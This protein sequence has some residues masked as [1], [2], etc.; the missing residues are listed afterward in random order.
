[1]IKKFLKYM[2]G[3][4]L[5]LIIGFLSTII[6]TR[7]VSPTEMGKY[8]LFTTI[9]NIIS[10]FI[11]L[12]FDQSYVRFFNEEKKANISNLLRKS[13]LVPLSFG[14]IIC[15]LVLI[16]YKWISTYIVGEIS[17]WFII[18]FCIYILTYIIFRIGL[19]HIRMKQKATMYSVLSVLQKLFFLIFAIIF[20]KFYGSKYIIL[21]SAIV[22]AE[23]IVSFLAIL[24][25]RK[26]WFNFKRSKLNT[27]FIEMLKYSFPFVFSSTITLL[28]QSTDKLML[29]YFTDYENIGIYAGAMNIV[30]VLNAFQAAFTTFWIPVAY[31]HY[32]NKPDDKDFFIR[33]N[34]YVAFLMLIMAISILLFKD[35][36]V[37]FLGEKYR[38]AIF[39]FPFLVFMPIMY[40][41]SETTVLGINFNKKSWY[42]VVISI[43]SLVTNFIGNYILIPIFNSKGAAISTGLS[44]IVFFICRTYFSKK[45]YNVKYE[46]KNFF[47]ATVLVYLFAI[48]CSFNTF[49]IIMI[50]FAFIVIIVNCLL[51]R[52]SLKNIIILAKKQNKSIK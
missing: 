50:L 24:F 30:A 26:D 44:Y 33:I 23:V 41:I 4:I 10:T 46:I 39:V 52:D 49:N 12:G 11:L 29:K 37:L 7:M 47:V 16:N 45:N 6:I 35:F 40:T 36:I 32:K 48:Y 42:H 43:I 13:L 51:Y 2:V 31:E 19:L 25:E 21:V 34:K 14:I 20:F 15:I 28:F 3:N 18:L 27:P 17:I 9:C 38:E 22:F 1:M 5:A 8:S